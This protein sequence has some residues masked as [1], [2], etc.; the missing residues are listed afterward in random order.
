LGHPFPIETFEENFSHNLT[1][2]EEKSG[3][4]AHAHGA[5]SPSAT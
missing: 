2:F 1:E 4:H 3:A 5:M